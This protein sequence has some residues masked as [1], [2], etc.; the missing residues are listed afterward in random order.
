M[1]NRDCESGGDCESAGWVLHL[2]EQCGSRPIPL[3]W[4][5]ARQEEHCV[6]FPTKRLLPAPGCFSPRFQSV[7]DLRHTFQKASALLGE[8][9][10][11]PS[12]ADPL[13]PA[14]PER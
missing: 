11:C 5:G 4:A 9:E 6:P 10:G 12:P 1:S 13:P 14:A 7:R 3:P 2:R 8:T